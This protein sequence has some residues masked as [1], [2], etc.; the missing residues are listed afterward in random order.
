MN[1]VRLSGRDFAFVLLTIF[2]LTTLQLIIKVKYK[3]NIGALF[4]R[5]KTLATFATDSN[6]RRTIKFKQYNNTSKIKNTNKQNESNKTNI[7]TK[8]KHHTL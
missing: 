7:K 8:N 2:E 3:K 1:S 4:G 5:T 6:C